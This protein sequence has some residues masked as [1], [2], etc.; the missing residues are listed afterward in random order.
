[1]CN[2]AEAGVAGGGGAGE[3]RSRTSDEDIARF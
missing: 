2:R 3:K 1:L